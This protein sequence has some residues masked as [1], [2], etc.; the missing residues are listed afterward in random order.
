MFSNIKNNF[1]SLLFVIF[2][3]SASAATTAGSNDYKCFVSG[4]CTNSLHVDLVS[5]EDKYDCL[6]KC[7]NNPSCTWFTFYPDWKTCQVS[8]SLNLWIKFTR[9]LDLVTLEFHFLDCFTK[10]F[11]K[12]LK[13]HFETF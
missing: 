12:L 2:N 7:K 11:L 5:S 1:W 10:K 6:E 8:F 9:L 13:D 3:L 4:E